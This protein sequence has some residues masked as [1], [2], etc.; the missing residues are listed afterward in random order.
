M[1]IANEAAQRVSV[2]NASH[3]ELLDKY[4]IVK[5]TLEKEKPERLHLQ[6]RVKNLEQSVSENKVAN[7]KL[8][9][10]LEAKKEEAMSLNKL[11]RQKQL[12]KVAHEKNIMK[13]NWKL[14]L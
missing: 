12:T 3:Q 5:E 14:M 9:R 1:N 13:Q 4:K 8:T 2:M 7:T 11:L 10:D 6:E